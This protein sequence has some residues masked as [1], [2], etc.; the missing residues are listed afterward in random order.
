MDAKELVEACDE[1]EAWVCPPC[2]GCDD[3]T[4]LSHYTGCPMLA[5]LKAQRGLKDMGFETSDEGIARARQYAALLVALEAW[6]RSDEHECKD[7]E[8]S[9]YGA[10]EE[11][12][13]LTL[14]A[15]VLQRDA[16]RAV[17]ATEVKP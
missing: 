1:I 10:C 4:G 11:S 2:D 16:A 8:R 17:L 5:W 7:C 14:K 13:E 12:V 9:G 15:A 6:Q 3:P